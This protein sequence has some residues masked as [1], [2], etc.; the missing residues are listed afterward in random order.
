MKRLYVIGMG[1]GGAEQLTPQALRA[2]EDSRVVCGYTTY[3]DLARGFLE[4][5]ELVT[6]PM[7]R[8]LERC[9]IAL[10]RAAAGR[11]LR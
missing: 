10:E 8:E 1:P 5:K 11:P 3:M 4:G 9:R 2:L 7:T 6:T